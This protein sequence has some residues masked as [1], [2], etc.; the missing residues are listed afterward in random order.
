VGAQSIGRGLIGDNICPKNKILEK[1]FL[2]KIKGVILQQILEQKITIL[3]LKVENI[4][5]QG[6][7]YFLSNFR[8]RFFSAA[9]NFR[10]I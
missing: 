8:L 5:K 6:C 10:R 3:A 1:L 2:Q 9:A 4:H 7:F